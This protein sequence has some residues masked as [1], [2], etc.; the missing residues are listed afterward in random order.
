MPYQAI[1]KDPPPLHADHTDNKIIFAANLTYFCFKP[2]P[3]NAMTVTTYQHR[4]SGT[5]LD[6]PPSCRLRHDHHQHRHSS[7]STHC[8]ILTVSQHRHTA[9]ISLSTV[10]STSQLACIL[11]FFV[12]Y[13]AAVVCCVSVYCI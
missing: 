8:H 5:A 11:P 13:L 6:S 3:T 12:F 1:P 10:H 4:Q 2:Q 9:L 7:L